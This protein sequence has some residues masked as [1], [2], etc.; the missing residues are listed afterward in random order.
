[1]KG[2]PVK[3]HPV[4]HELGPIWKKPAMDNDTFGIHND[5]PFINVTMKRLVSSLF[6]KDPIQ[7]VGLTEISTS[8]TPGIFRTMGEIL[9]E[10]S[11]T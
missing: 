10:N 8:F 11:L 1:M 3:G 9:S 5:S 2:H 4:N 6:Q 7:V